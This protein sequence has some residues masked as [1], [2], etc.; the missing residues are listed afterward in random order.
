MIFLSF[1]FLRGSIDHPPLNFL[2]ISSELL[3]SKTEEGGVWGAVS[4]G[5]FRTG[6]SVEG[7]IFNL[8]T[9]FRFCEVPLL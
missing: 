5:S 7:L 6:R 4:V 3:G 2:G 1:S 9:T 8:G